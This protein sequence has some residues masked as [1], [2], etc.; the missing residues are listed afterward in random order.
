[1]RG[2]VSQSNFLPWRGYFAS[3]R[4]SNI[5]VFYDSQNFTRRDWRNRNVLLNDLKAEWITLPLKTKGEYNSPI[6]AIQLA[7]P[8]SIISIS[9]KVR[10]VY[11][12]YSKTDGYRFL[13]DLFKKS[14][15]FKFLSEINHFLT[16]EIANYLQI[17]ILFRSDAELEISGGKN[18]KLIDV[19]NHFGISQYL[20]GPSATS[21]LETEVFEE[22]RISVEIIDF[23]K[24]PKITLKTEPSIAHWIITQSQDECI[25]L[26]TFRI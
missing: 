11:G 2:I 17:E 16:K 5:L 21:Y 24:L 3:I 20:S 25:E 23:S 15:D 4:E 22:N 26:T 18:E 10:G 12:Q 1:M 7:G 19:C 8:S 13:I 9:N 14:Q 6:N